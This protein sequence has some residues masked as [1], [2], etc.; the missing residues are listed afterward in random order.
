ME[1]AAQGKD[2]ELILT[3][4][5][6]TRQRESCIREFSAYVIVAEL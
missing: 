3:T 5:M 1:C 4:K 2:Y 6:E